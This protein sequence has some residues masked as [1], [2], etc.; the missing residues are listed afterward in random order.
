MPKVHICQ[1]SEVIQSLP[2]IQSFNSASSGL[3]KNF[4]LFICALGFEERC[5]TVP[6]KLAEFG[7]KSVRAGY[8]EYSTNRDDNETNRPSLSQQLKIIS[9]SIQS[10]EADDE[11]FTGELRELLSSI[12]HQKGDAKPLVLFDTSVVSNRLMMRCFKVLLEFDINLVLLYS[13]AAIYHPTRAEYEQDPQ[14]WSS[15][16]TIG[17][18]RG[19]SDVSIS[20]EYPGYHI[21]QLPDCIILFPNIKKVRSRAIIDK[22]DPSLLTSPGNNVIWLLGIPHADQD[23]WRLEAM[24]AILELKED[25]PQFEVNTFDYKDALSKLDSIYQS[26]VEQ[27]KFT[28]GLMGSNMQTIGAALFCYLRPS[29][30]VVFATPE[31]YN[32]SQYSEGC[33]ATW[34]IDLG[35]L[36]ELR[37]QLDKAGMLII[38][39]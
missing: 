26:R 13:E 23:H 11:K 19:V 37:N 20:E 9:G 29:V 38:E 1:F 34:M 28:L 2:E 35:S 24:R 7:Y 25:I 21:D 39:D 3:E 8:F 14:K 6:Q 18:E 22:V 31:E 10:F 17:I 12:K 30:R 32:A 4:D 27:N 16:E 15:D 5:L 33:K 36:K